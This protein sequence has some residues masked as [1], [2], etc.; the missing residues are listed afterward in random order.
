MSQ[1]VER[2]SS[3]VENY[4]KYRPGYP[5]EILNLLKTECGLTVESTIADLG[6]G[7]GKLADVFLRHGYSVIGVEPN[8]GMRAA[9]EQILGVY[10]NFTSLNG[11]AE[12]TTLPNSSIDLITAGQAFHW[13]DQRLTR[14]EATRILKASGW[15]ALIWNDRKLDTTP[16]L[17]DY[18][19][20][21]LK[22]GSDYQEVRHDKAE[23]EIAKFFDGDQVTLKIFQNEQV[24]DL[25]GLR[26]RV[27]SSSYTPE[28]D[29]PSFQP[30]MDELELLFEKHQANGRVVLDYDTKVF[31]GRLSRESRLS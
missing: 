24:V 7:T 1:S 28:P 31:Y 22:Y 4:V 29:N 18:E 8:A 11:T 23:G 30:M 17:R 10:S 20:L 5:S 25:D 26:G 21:L 6:S 14:L 13:F 27:L 3:R 19:S 9:A 15:V 12:S 16:F 2:F